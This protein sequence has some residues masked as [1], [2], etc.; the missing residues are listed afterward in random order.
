[1]CLIHLFYCSSDNFWRNS[2]DFCPNRSDCL[3]NSLLSNFINFA[4]CLADNFWN[5]FTDFVNTASPFICEV[6][7]IEKPVRLTTRCFLFSF[8]SKL[9]SVFASV[10]VNSF[11][12]ISSSDAAVSLSLHS[13]LLNFLV[14]LQDMQLCL[15]F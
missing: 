8:G 14:Q 4:C 3:I 7:A 15:L 5:N 13:V 6:I 1:M 10:S 9:P 11:L 2:F 12:D